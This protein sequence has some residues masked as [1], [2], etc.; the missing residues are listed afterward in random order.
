MKR[1]RGISLITLVITIVIIIILA[2]VGML[3]LSQNNP[4]KNSEKARIMEDVSVFAS[5]LAVRISKL[6]ADNPGLNM[7]NID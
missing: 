2:G 7:K 1:I 4:I 6:Y 3:N 5:D